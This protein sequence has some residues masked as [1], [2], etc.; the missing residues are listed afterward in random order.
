M[1][2]TKVSTTNSLNALVGIDFRIFETDL[3]A[4]FEKRESDGY[5]LLVIPTSLE[6]DNGISIG[7]MIKE[8][9]GL[10][11]RVDENANTDDMEKNLQ[12]GVSGLTRDDDQKFDLDKLMIKLRMAFLYIEKTAEKSTIEYAFQ[13]E[14]ITEGM[15]PAK[16]RSL[17][18]VNNVSISVWNTQRKQLI[19]KMSLMT[20]NSY[21][22]IADQ[23]PLD[24]APQPQPKP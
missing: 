12:N 9:K 18:D 22:G 1:A 23:Q 24:P 14:I 3:H 7:N 8:I 17:V 15:I 5:A 6:A 19:E 13:L 4:G 10:V 2:D 20:V 16:I 11:S 21:L